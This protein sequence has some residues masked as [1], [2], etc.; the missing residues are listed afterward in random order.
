LAKKLKEMAKVRS[1]GLASHGMYQIFQ[2]V[3]GKIKTRKKKELQEMW[4]PK[5]SEL[6]E[7]RP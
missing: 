6:H 7:R 3:H 4:K 5:R 1:G 2:E